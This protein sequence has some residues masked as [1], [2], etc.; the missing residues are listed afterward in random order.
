MPDSIIGQPLDRIDG[1][2]KV[3]GRALYSADRSVDD[4]AY[5]HIVTA[6]IAHGQIKTINTVSTDDAGKSDAA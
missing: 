1:H 3:M 6:A 4:L 2:A 5:G